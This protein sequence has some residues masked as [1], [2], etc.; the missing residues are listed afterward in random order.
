MQPKPG[1]SPED[2]LLSDIVVHAGVAFQSRKNAQFLLLFAR[3][4]D[5]PGMLKVSLMGHNT[6]IPVVSVPDYYSET[7]FYWKIIF[8][9]HALPCTH[10]QS[11]GH[12]G[13]RLYMERENNFP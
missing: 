10:T 4:M 1:M 13:M 2:R 8:P 11:L 5:S 9:F 12:I 7:L 3:M 6:N